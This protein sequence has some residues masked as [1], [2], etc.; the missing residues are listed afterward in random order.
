M[1]IRLYSL[2]AS[3]RKE[4]VKRIDNFRPS[5]YT[6]FHGQ[7]ASTNTKDLETF[8][9]EIIVINCEVR[10]VYYT[11][12]LRLTLLLLY[13]TLPYPTLP[14]PTLPYPTLPYPTLPEWCSTRA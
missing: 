7:I 8:N 14:Y 5:L 9:I 11:L 13:P 2:E 12:N 3:N 4:E 1:R 10:G 6:V